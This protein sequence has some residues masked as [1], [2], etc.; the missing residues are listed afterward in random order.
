[1]RSFARSMRVRSFSSSGASFDFACDRTNIGTVS[2]A[3]PWIG[4]GYDATHDQM[5]SVAGNQSIK[6]L[7]FRLGVAD[8]VA[9]V[10]WIA[11]ARRD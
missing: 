5:C 8:S 1:M 9:T 4:A 6:G 11:D 10:P 7:T 2:N 3:T